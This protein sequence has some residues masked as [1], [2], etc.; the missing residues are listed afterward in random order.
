MAPAKFS[1]AEP[2]ETERLMEI[3]YCGLCHSDLEPL[4]NYW[5]TTKYPYVPG[6]VA[7]D[8]IVSTGPDV[9]QYQRG[10]IVGVDTL[11]DSY[12]PCSACE[13]HWENHCELPNGPTMIHGAYLTPGTREAS[14][15]NAY[16]AWAENAVV[17]KHFVVRILRVLVW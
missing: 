14:K 13:E 2:K 5:N 4:A 17:K 16:G 10:D 9:K 15:F 7:V 1:R 12:L 6:H 8:R 11:M 3:L